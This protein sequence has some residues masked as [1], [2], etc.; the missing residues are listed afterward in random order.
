[1][2]R[3]YAEQIAKL[4]DALTLKEGIDK[5]FILDSKTDAKYYLVV[6]LGKRE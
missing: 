5:I 1:M 3:V 4:N 6:Y 2:K